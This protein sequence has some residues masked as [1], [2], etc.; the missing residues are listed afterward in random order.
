MTIETANHQRGREGS[1]AAVARAPAHIRAAINRTRVS[2]GLQPILGTAERAALDEQLVATTV[3]AWGEA[4][5]GPGVWVNGADGRLAPAPGRRTPPRP[6][7]RTT[8]RRRTI[9]RVLLMP[10]YGDA[11][12]RCVSRALPEIVA[13]G[14]FGSAD[15]LNESRNWALRDGHSG[16]FL[17]YAGD[18][19]RAIDTPSGLVVEWRPDLT[20]PW[21]RDAVRAI[22]DGH[23]G[24]SVG[25]V[26]RGRRSVRIPSTVEMITSATL[27]DV[28]LLLRGERG[29]YPGARAKVFRN[30]EVDDDAE[31]ARQMAELLDRCRWYTRQATR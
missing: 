4:S 14:A 16:P 26:I 28:A 29:A 15:E 18:R 3:A 12:A 23:N 30:V 11:A 8:T 22:E 1:E 19:L 25:M 13:R 7:G 21:A 6:A 9:T 17:Q 31:L 2:R 27:V 20:L 5:R 24:A 10:T